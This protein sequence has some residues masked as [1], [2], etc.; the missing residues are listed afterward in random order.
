MDK[1]REDIFW[2]EDERYNWL[3]VLR[4][5]VKVKPN[6]DQTT[7]ESETKKSAKDLKKEKKE[8]FRIRQNY[9]SDQVVNTPNGL[10]SIIS[11][12]ENDKIVVETQKDEKT[13]GAN[14]I[15]SYL[16][17]SLKIVTKKDQFLRQALVKANSKVK[18]LKIAIK[19]AI[20]D[21]DYYYMTIFHNSEIFSQ[22]NSTL[23]SDIESLQA[24]KNSDGKL[25]EFQ[26]LLLND[27]DFHTVK[28]FTGI[29]LQDQE[30]RDNGLQCLTRAIKIIGFGIMGLNNYITRNF[31]NFE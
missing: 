2:F 22:K 12:E 1:D 7:N 13:Y 15:S 10:T 31:I 8:L 6:T 4:N 25:P 18:Q 5:S 9:E 23:L 20:E 14:D 27:Q 26:V 3:A 19:K 16:K 29:S 21:F 28:L 11:I 30:V 17:I 24:K